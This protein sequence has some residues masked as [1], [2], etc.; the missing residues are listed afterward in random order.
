MP[1]K[2]TVNK[3]TIASILTL[4]VFGFVV[5]WFRIP[6]WEKITDLYR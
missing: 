3:F 2:A 1:S 4:I 6:I 5:F